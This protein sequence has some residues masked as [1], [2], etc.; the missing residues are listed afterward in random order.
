MRRPRR[1]ERERDGRD[2]PQR[3][4]RPKK[5]S[6]DRPVVYGLLPVLELLR[7]G[8]RRID[9]IVVVDGAR[10]SRISEILDLARQ[11]DI[12]VDRVGRE[13]FSRFLPE[14]ANHQGVLAFTSAAEYADADEILS[15]LGETALILILDG[16]EDPEIS[17]HFY[18]PPSPPV[19]TVF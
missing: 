15:G 3:N 10:E 6:A 2:G 1:Q 19:L 13:N 12:L 4:T 7:A 16:I 11:R 14:D 5:K 8:S 17:V 18:G 9:K